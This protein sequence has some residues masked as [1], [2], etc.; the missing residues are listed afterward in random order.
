[1]DKIKS[2]VDKEELNKF[3]QI[4]KKEITPPCCFSMEC[5]L[6]LFNQAV[7]LASIKNLTIKEAVKITFRE[8]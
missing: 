8:R 7:H 1:M 4:C 6:Q 3:C 2:W 5:P